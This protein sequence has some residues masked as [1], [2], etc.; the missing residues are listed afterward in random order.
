MEKHTPQEETIE[1]RER[2]DG[3]ICFGGVDWWYHNRGH[4]DLRIMRELAPEMPVLYVNSIGVRMPSRKEEGG[5]IFWARVRRKLRSFKNGLKQATPGFWV[6]SP[7]YAPTDRMRAL[8]QRVLV[9]QVKFAARRAGIKRPLV[10]VACPA[11][12]EAAERIGGVGIVHQRTDRFEAFPSGTS[13]HLVG[14]IEDL[15]RVSDLNVFCARN[16]FQEEETRGRAAALV[17]HGVDH[18][19]FEKAGRGDFMEPEGFAGIP[20]PRVGFVGGID[21]HT[22][23]PPLFRKVVEQMPEVQFMLTG[24]CSLPDD[25]LD[26]PNVHFLGKAAL[27]DVPA[28]MASSD[29]LVMPWNRSPWIQGCNPV[30]L[31]EYLAVGRPVVSTSFP[32]LDHYEGLVRVADEAD[33]FADAIRAA[34]T[35]PHDAEPGRA[36]V[37]AASWNAKAKETLASLQRLG[38]KAAAGFMLMGFAL[39]ACTTPPTSDPYPGNVAA[40]V[41]LGTVEYRIAPGDE[42]T[43]RFPT[44]PQWTSDILVQPDGNASVPLLGTVRFAGTTLTELQSDLEI[45]LTKR[46]RSPQVELAIKALHPRNIYV[47]GEVANPGLIDMGAAQ[48]N[49]TQAIFARG[50]PVHRTAHMDNVVL[51]R[52]NAAGE[53]NS[54][55]VDVLGNLEGAHEPIALLPGDV[56]LVPNR[57]VAEA[58]MFIEQYITGMI[59][60]SNIL[61]GLILTQ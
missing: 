6:F 35:E 61:A 39:P 21:E 40:G 49:L 32:E 31:K 12:A 10:W 17:D 3:V 27:E 41:P 54:W 34:L 7:I 19:R 14:W 57:P 28:H 33:A 55:V 59:P 16:L 56:V 23:D 30:K 52:V 4:Y 22:F 18:E 9:W 36:R 46:V 48:M 37:R 11:A 25:A 50:G 47:G 15:F 44:Y 42:I 5:S 43:V 53:R 8:M 58:N 60:G 24:G 20:H 29:V 38:L 2:F 1:T 45:A 51:S 13:E 26:L